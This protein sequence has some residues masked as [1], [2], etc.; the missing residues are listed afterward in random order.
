MTNLNIARFYR[1][2]SHIGLIGFTIFQPLF[3]FANEHVSFPFVASASEE[4]TVNLLNETSANNSRGLAAVYS[5]LMGTE[6]TV[7]KNVF[8]SIGM[9][10]WDPVFP[11]SADIGSS[12]IARWKFGK[13]SALTISYDDGAIGNALY[14][15]PAMAEKGLVGTWFVNPGTS[16]FQKMSEVW[17]QSVTT[18]NQEIANHTMNHAGGL[19][20]AEALAAINDASFYIKEQIYK[21]PPQSTK[22][23]GFNKAGGT[24]WDIP[25]TGEQWD[26]RIRENYLIERKYSTGFYK[27]MPASEM[28][29]V[30][31]AKSYSTNWSSIHFHGICDDLNDGNINTAYGP[32]YVEVCS[33]SHIPP[34]CDPEPAKGDPDYLAQWLA[35]A[36]CRFTS[37][38]NNAVAVSDCLDGGIGAVKK[39][40]ILQ[41]YDYL[42]DK[43]EIPAQSIWIAGFVESQ[44]YAIERDN[45][46]V[47]LVSADIDQVR[48]NVLLQTILQPAP[49]DQVSL[50]D[51]DLTLF[52]KVPSS[53]TACRVTQ[54]GQAHTY[55]IDNGE[56]RFEVTPNN[57]EILLE[58]DTVA[59][60]DIPYVGDP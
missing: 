26:Q 3:C 29:M 7:K 45:A 32:G 24:N 39:N 10:S 34:Q 21:I 55:I 1:L 52:V 8:G 44:K 42:T 47:H 40:E 15:I 14:G 25:T 43:D 20:E 2:L 18:Y 30:V 35:W 58:N 37:G 12:M 50:Y 22:L 46:T 4:K 36:E 51:E 23:L 6:K 54:N 49:L 53:W 33:C 60:I 11:D 13:H 5:L 48:L 31:K 27:A 57:G 16:T 19:T 28:E 41:F 38:Y 17:H 9:P 59:H 56:T